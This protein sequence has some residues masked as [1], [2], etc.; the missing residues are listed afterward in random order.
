MLPQAVKVVMEAVDAA[1][2]RPSVLATNLVP[3]RD[4]FARRFI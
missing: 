1:M 3:R 4:R 2:V